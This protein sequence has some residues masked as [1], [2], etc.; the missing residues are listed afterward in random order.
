[1]DS[2][3]TASYC[4]ELAEDATGAI[5]GVLFGEQGILAG[6]IMMRTRDSETI[7]YW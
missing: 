5:D 3:Y 4:G 2:C 6:L 1:M 7:S